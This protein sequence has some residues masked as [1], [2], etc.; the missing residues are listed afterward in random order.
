MP[1]AVYNGETIEQSGEPWYAPYVDYAKKNGIISSDYT[2]QELDRPAKRFEVTEMIRKAL[3][4]GYFEAVNS[5]SSIP[6]VPDDASYCAGTL[7]LYNAGIVM[8]SDS[9]GT[10]NPDADIT[11]AEAS[12]TSTAWPCRKRD[13][14]RRLKR[15]R[16]PMR[17]FWHRQLPCPV[18]NKVYPPVGCLTT[19]AAFENNAYGRI[20]RVE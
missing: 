10:F 6:D 17:I 3:S 16:I 2:A 11:R 18:P 15:F 14:K 1:G 4:D 12:A 9:I 8:G 5:V 7:L 13:L 19:A 20:R